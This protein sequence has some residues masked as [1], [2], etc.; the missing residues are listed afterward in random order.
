[1]HFYELAGEQ[2]VLVEFFAPSAA[3]DRL[4]AL[5][6]DAGLALFWTNSSEK[7][8]IGE[9]YGQDKQLGID[10]TGSTV[11]LTNGVGN[12]LTEAVSVTSVGTVTLRVM[13]SKFTV[14]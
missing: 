7:L 11:T 6:T 14:D 3:I 13:P 1:M 8:F 10:N 12:V 5:A 2:P 4:L 9:I